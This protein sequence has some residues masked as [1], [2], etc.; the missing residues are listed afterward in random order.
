M[1]RGNQANYSS[2]RRSGHQAGDNQPAVAPADFEIGIRGQDDRVREDFAHA[3]KTA[4]SQAHGDFG[5]LI[6]ES[7]HRLIAQ[8]NYRLGIFGRRH[9]LGVY[10]KQGYP[11]FF[12]LREPFAYACQRRIRESL[13]PELSARFQKSLPKALTW[14]LVDDEGDGKQDHVARSALQFSAE[15]AH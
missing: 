2:P 1:D 9:P 5:V 13:K 3:H 14:D 15:R 11:C 4:I 7:E 10:P 6:H 12:P 8:V